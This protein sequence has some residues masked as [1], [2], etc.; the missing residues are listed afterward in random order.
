MIQGYCFH[1]LSELKVN[2][3]RFNFTGL[4]EWLGPE[5]DQNQLIKNVNV[6]YETIPF[7][8]NNSLKGNILTQTDPIPR[9][10]SDV[11]FGI[12]LETYIQVF[13]E[14]GYKLEELSELRRNILSFFKLAINSEI[15]PYIQRLYLN[16]ITDK[17]QHFPTPSELVYFERFDRTLNK[18]DFRDIRFSYKDIK[19]NFN[20]IFTIWIDKAS[21]LAPII[22][23]LEVL[24]TNLFI[25]NKFL[26]ICQALEGLHS[27]CYQELEEYSSN[28]LN[29]YNQP[30]FKIR[31]KRLI[32]RFSKLNSKYFPENE[33]DLNELTEQI[34]KTRNFHTHLYEKT[35]GLL[36]ETM[37]IEITNK[38]ITVCYTLIFMSIEIPPN[39]ISSFVKRQNV[40]SSI[41]ISDIPE[42][43]K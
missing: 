38:L 10:N 2:I 8:I 24:K 32:N 15:E 7:N 28:E 17:H 36:N 34:R 14:T 20:Q 33:A 40:I 19:E 29:S 13:S 12:Y 18:V 39:I 6:N 22:N 31:I 43:G 27:R 3:Y 30:H 16:S 9:E 5:I 21:L 37:L 4:S 23:L 35:D 42:A 41:Y 11:L 26:I 1:D 25:E